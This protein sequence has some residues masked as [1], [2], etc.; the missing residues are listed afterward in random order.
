MQS[1]VLI[2]APVNPSMIVVLVSAATLLASGRTPA[3]PKNAMSSSSIEPDQTTAT[4]SAHFRIPLGGPSMSTSKLDRATS[5][6]L[7]PAKRSISTATAINKNAENKNGQNSVDHLRAIK[8][9]DENDED[10]EMQI[11]ADENANPFPPLPSK[12][13]RQQLSHQPESN[14]SKRA[15]PSVDSGFGEDAGTA[16]NV[17]DRSAD[18]RVAEDDIPDSQDEGDQLS[19]SAL[20][21]RTVKMSGSVQQWGD[22]RGKQSSEKSIAAVDQSSSSMPRTAAANNN[23]EDITMVSERSFFLSLPFE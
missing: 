5:T 4:T 16:Q 21:R 20:S 14:A 22:S 19:A 7:V 9:K 10:A 3:T 1:P 11:I 6:K 15:R 8:I 23:S 18:G 2:L 12:Q 17:L 13:H